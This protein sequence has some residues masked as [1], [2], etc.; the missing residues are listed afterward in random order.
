MCQS[1]VRNSE[2]MVDVD[3]IGVL[4]M[5]QSC[6]RYLG[7]AHVN[8]AHVLEVLHSLVRDK[9]AVAEADPDRVGIPKVDQSCVGNKRA[10]AQVDR[11]SIT[12]MSKCS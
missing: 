12:E 2:A 10:S 3:D 9:I 7:P 4:K 1:G 8:V 6:V 5:C 11:M